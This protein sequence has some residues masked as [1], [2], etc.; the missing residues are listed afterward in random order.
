[1]RDR[2]FTFHRGL[3]D[4]FVLSKMCT[5]VLSLYKRGWLDHETKSIYLVDGTDMSWWNI[6]A[7]TQAKHVR[8]RGE[9]LRC[10]AQALEFIFMFLNASYVCNGASGNMY[11]CCMV[12][13][14][15]CLHG[16]SN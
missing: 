6:Q 9:Y 14:D 12:Q 10:Q 2:N 3:E 13:V 15:L 5:F 1:M 16:H 4:R 11:L 8:R 7:R